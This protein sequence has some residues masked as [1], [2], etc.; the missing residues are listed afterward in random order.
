MTNTEILERAIQKAIK[1]GWLNPK[2]PVKSVV[3]QADDGECYFQLW[4]GTN[5]MLWSETWDSVE[6]LIFN[7][8][9]ARGLWKSKEVCMTCGYGIVSHDTKHPDHDYISDECWKLHLQRMVI[10]EDPIKY[11]G[12]NI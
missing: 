10:S 11:L 9:F 7:H 1:G 3:V 6:Q 4:A 2:K 5:D 8:D 12:E